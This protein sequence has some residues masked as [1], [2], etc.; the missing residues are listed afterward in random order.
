MKKFND[1]NRIKKY[2]PPFWLRNGHI[3]TIFASKFLK[4]DFVPYYRE[5]W[6]TPDGDFIDVDL[7]QGENKK[8]LIIGHGLEG[9]SERPYIQTAARFFFERDW[10]VIAWNSRS[11]SGEMNLRPKLYSHGDTADLDF[12]VSRATEMDYKQIALVGFSMGGAIILNGLGRQGSQVKGPIVAAVA[13]SAPCDIRAASQNL[14]KGFK[15]LY[16]KYFLDKLKEKVKR[17]AAQFPGFLD[18]HG[19]DDIKRWRE[20]DER[21]SAPLNGLSG[22]DSFYEF[23]SANERLDQIR[24]PTLIINALDDPILSDQDYPRKGIK[25]NKYLHGYFPKFGGHV[26][27]LQ[28]PIDGPSHAE[29]AALQFISQFLD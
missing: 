23:S 28:Y 22:A 17:K 24:I 13:I 3:H 14:E 27:F 12:V 11:C 16:G 20:F 29:Q 6:D 10:D 8:V 21:F 9:S 15:K 5:R 25:S 18:T 26:G 2:R 4:T 19:I 7:L 1:V